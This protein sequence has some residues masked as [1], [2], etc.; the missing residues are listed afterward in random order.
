MDNRNLEKAVD[1]FGALVSGEEISR[2]SGKNIELY[3]EFTE[4]AEVNNIVDVMLRRLNLKL[5]EYKDSIFVTA[6]D[7]NRLF[8]YSN[9]ELKKNMG[10]RLN[11]ELYL[12][13]F[14]IYKIITGFYNSSGSYTYAEYVKLEDIISSVDSSL[15][16]IIANL[17]V[18]VRDEIEE[19]SFK[20]LG[21]L[22][23]E[24]PIVGSDDNS[25]VKAS[26]GSKVGFVKMV[27][28]F[29]ISQGLF[30]ES[31]ERYYPKERFKAI[32]TNYFEEER[33]RLYEILNREEVDENAP[34]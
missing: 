17:N 33:G 3:E 10:I 9:E 30:L 7:H 31:E 13:Y 11:K 6:G 1:I 28:N 25:V 23:A 24:L 26:R 18:M 22:W 14:I 4:N 8:G 32:A 5:Y 19:N 21:I 12:A 29:L 20:M 2:N 16:N 34:Y 27:F 15:S